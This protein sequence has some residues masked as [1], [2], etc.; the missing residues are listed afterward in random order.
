[1]IID[2]LFFS[3]GGCRDRRCYQ[4]SNANNIGDLLAVGGVPGAIQ[5]KNQAFEHEPGPRSSGT[6]IVKVV[7]VNTARCR[8]GQSPHPSSPAKRGRVRE[9]AADRALAAQAT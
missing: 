4:I 2:A 9:G 5:A 1:M 6:L 7:R 8:G 3:T